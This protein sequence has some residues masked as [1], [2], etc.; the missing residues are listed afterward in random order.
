MIKF[1]AF[2]ETM[3]G[4]QLSTAQRVLART[5]DGEA[6]EGDDERAMFT[7]LFAMDPDTAI[8]P[9]AQRV[10]FLL[11]GSR[12]GGT[13]IAASFGL[14]RALTTSLDQL[15]PGERCFVGFTSADV[16]L[17][18]EAL[19]QAAS[20]ID[21]NPSIL[22]CVESRSTEKIEIRRPHDGRV[23]VLQCLPATPSAPRGRWFAMVHISECDYLGGADG[24]APAEEVVRAYAARL[25]RDGKLLAESTPWAEGFFSKLYSSDFGSPRSALVCRAPTLTLYPT[26]ETRELVEK[27]QKRDPT[28]AS[29]EFFC[30]WIT[31]GSAYFDRDAIDR[32]IDHERAPILSSVEGDRAVCGLDAAFRGDACAMTI[33][34]SNEGLIE[35]ARV[36]IR[37]PT[38]GK[39]LAPSVVLSD[40]ATIAREYGCRL[41]CADGYALDSVREVFTKF[42][43]KVI[44]TGRSSEEKGRA[45]AHA[46][47]MIHQSRV[48]FAPGD[49]VDDLRAVVSRPTSGGGTKIEQPRTGRGHGD[50]ASSFVHCL[51]ALRRGAVSLTERS[52]VFGRRVM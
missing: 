18:R 14:Y 1:V 41:A 2:L 45:Y 8:A 39:P 27:E 3:V 26:D 20:T 44:V 42:G 38:K 46:K 10:F 5:L 51:W 12:C 15:R 4:L 25:I 11:K 37:R 40:L 23:V 24:A 49:L 52:F 36:E 28:N 35:V 47:E 43:I 33:A 32:C 21:R 17:A 13:L 31:G 9:E 29:R 19:A 7:E 50:A 22:S 30:V 48:R 34:R 16:R 6:L